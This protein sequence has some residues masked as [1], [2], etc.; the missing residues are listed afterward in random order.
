MVY[1]QCP[2]I[3][4]A[5][6]VDVQAIRS[7][8]W[9]GYQDLVSSSGGLFENGTYLAYMLGIN[10]HRGISRIRTKTFCRIPPKKIG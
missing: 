7:D 6:P 9:T 1:D 8:L 3:V 5:Y 4:L 10:S 2:C